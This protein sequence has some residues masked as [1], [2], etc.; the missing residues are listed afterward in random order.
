MIKE[1]KVKTDKRQQIIDITNQVKKIVKESK[2]K[3]GI[4][5]VY[6]QHTT[7]ALIINENHD[8]NICKDIINA[9]DKLVQEDGWLHNK[10]DNNAAAHIKAAIMGPSQTI[11]IQDNELQLGRWQSIQI[12]DFDG[13]RERIIKVSILPSE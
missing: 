5:S 6:V 10:I 1:I 9:F 2:V 4:V 13:P 7:A 8:P 3:E 12:V 11:P